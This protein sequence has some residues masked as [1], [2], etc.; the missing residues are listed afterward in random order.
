MFREKNLQMSRSYNRRDDQA[1]PIK[2]TRNYLKN[3][4]GSV[5]IEIGDTKVICT[6][7]VEESVPNHRKNS[8]LG[9]VTAEYAMIPRAT[10]QR[11]Q[12]EHFG[13]VKGRTQEIQRL[14]GRSLR[15]V[16]DFKELGERTIT[17]DADVIQADGGTRTASI[18]G[19]FVAMYDAMLKL[20]K[21][22]KINAIPVKDFL[23]AVSCGILNKNILLDLDYSE[24][25]IADVDMNVVMTES[26]KLVEIQGTAEAD[27]FSEE[28]LQALLSVAKK[29]IFEIIKKQKETLK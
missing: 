20:K 10:T 3:P 7:T 12:R 13:K 25:S 17:L 23:A 2:I 9:W 19:C 15:A 18:S 6:A 26:G 4:E 1:R 14:I 29:G 16:V 24:D 27:P 28:D 22:G 5:L 21:S 11:T 8:G